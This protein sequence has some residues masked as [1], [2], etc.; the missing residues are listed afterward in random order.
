MDI[1]VAHADDIESTAGVIEALRR[2]HGPDYDFAIGRWEGRTRF[3]PQPGRAS[4]RFIIASDRGAAA[5]RRGDLVRGPAPDGPYRGMA[6]GD[7]SLAEV[8]EA[9]VEALWPGDVIALAG[10]A[11][12]ALVL[13]GRGSYFEVT[14]EQ[15]AYRAPKLTMLRH[16]SDKPGGC[17]AYPGA[18]RREAL[19]PLRPAP[20]DADRRGANRVNEH[21]LDMRVDR[22]P[23][24]VRH[25]HGPVSCGDGRAANHSETAIVLSRSVYGLPEVDAPDQGHIVIYR[26]PAEDPADKVII[27]VRPG[28]IVVTPATTGQVMGH[29]FE[30]A[31]AMLLA[32]PGFVSPS[33]FI[34][35]DQ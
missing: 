22:R 25:Y 14:T 33:N 24:P 6:G 23:G 30:N 10:D 8:T 13:H 21:T 12:E 32:I 34:T 11:Q 7:S 3:E 4:Y 5:L 17:A 9:R 26:R 2:L 19:P 31:F 35:G 16:L 29:C 28:S 1:P 18:F 20:A 15:T 27:P